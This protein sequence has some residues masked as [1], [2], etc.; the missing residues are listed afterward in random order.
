MSVVMR[1][2]NACASAAFTRL[3]QQR[4]AALRQLGKIQQLGR[5]RDDRRSRLRLRC[6]PPAT[7]EHHSAAQN[8]AKS[9]ENSLVLHVSHSFTKLSGPT[10]YATPSTHVSASE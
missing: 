5:R 10:A 3:I 8:R 6:G 9:A 4:L 7:G 2:R 1:Q